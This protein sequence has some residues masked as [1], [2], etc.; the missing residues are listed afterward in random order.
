MTARHRPTR[1]ERALLAALD[2]T[3]PGM[4]VDEALLDA[5]VLDTLEPEMRAAFEDAMAQSLP[6]QARVASARRFAEGLAE[7]AAI[8]PLLRVA[9]ATTGGAARSTP[10]AASPPMRSRWR[11]PRTWGALA[12]AALLLVMVQRVVGPPSAPIDRGSELSLLPPLDDG[13]Q[14]WVFA[15][16]GTVQDVRGVDA[17]DRAR[18]ERFVRAALAGTPS[19]MTADSARLTAAVP[20]GRLIMAA[21]RWEAG[22]REGARA[23]LAPLAEAS[24]QPLLQAVVDA[25][26]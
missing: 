10:L 13:G 1:D 12:A 5:Y 6:L 25:L 15:A 19:P 20:T 23:T 7:P 4:W 24:R 17:T 26:R 22:N 18:V 16:N 11:Q 3:D 9:A 21:V 2:G 14:R 8:P